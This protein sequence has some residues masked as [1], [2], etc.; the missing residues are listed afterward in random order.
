MA[1]KTPDELKIEDKGGGASEAGSVPE[2]ERV[3]P[4]VEADFLG[5][6]KDYGV[7]EKAAKIVTKHIA[8][9]GTENV[10]EDPTQLLEKLVKFSRQIPPVTR[11][12]ILDHWT[13][14][15]KIPVPEGFEKEAAMS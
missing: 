10:F 13:T 6:L 9:T 3:T 12:N 11:K 5:L 15:R 7:A 4:D 1:E 14:A 2:E 8:E